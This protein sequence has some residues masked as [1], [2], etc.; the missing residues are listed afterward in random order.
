MRPSSVIPT[1]RDRGTA[2]GAREDVA[3]VEPT[4]LRLEH[5]DLDVDAG[6]REDRD[7][8]PCT[9]ASGSTIAATTRDAPLA[10]IAS[11]H[12]G[13]RPWWQQGSSVT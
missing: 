10:R 5:P 2:F 4:T 3:A 6:V 13:V 12:G 9:R 8:L 7:P 11:V 1:S